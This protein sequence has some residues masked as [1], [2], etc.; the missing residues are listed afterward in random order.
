V[1]RIRD[2]YPGPRILIFTRLLSRISDPGLEVKKAPDPGSRNRIRNTATNFLFTF[3]K[4]NKWIQLPHLEP[5]LA[6]LVDGNEVVAVVGRAVRLVLEG[7]LLRKQ[8]DV[9]AGEVYGPGIRVV[10]KISENFFGEIFSLNFRNSLNVLYVPILVPKITF[11]YILSIYLPATSFRQ[12]GLKT[13]NS[14]KFAKIN[15]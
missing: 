10:K 3:V 7:A 15:I 8:A 12:D 6:L 11:L 9:D 4:A 13:E 5:V 2:V 14:G 1:L